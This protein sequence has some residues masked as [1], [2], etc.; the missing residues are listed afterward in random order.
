MINIILKTDEMPSLIAELAGMDASGREAKKGIAPPVD[1]I[2]PEV[3]PEG[4][5]MLRVPAFFK[6]KN[7]RKMIITPQTLEGENTDSPSMVQSPIVRAIKNAHAWKAKL[8][9]GEVASIA[10]L[11][12]TLGYK[13]PYV[14]RILSLTL[15]APDIVE[16]IINGEEPNGLSLEKLVSGFPE[17][18]EEQREVFDFNNCSVS[19]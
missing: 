12:R 5:I 10:E 16:A 9:S 15:L 6:Y 1:G 18:W 19:L 11:A 8:E 2:V 13:R 3:L 4:R 14:T 7:G 17:D